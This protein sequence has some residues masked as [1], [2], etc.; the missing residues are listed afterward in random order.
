MQLP[1]ERIEVRPQSRRRDVFRFVIVAGAV[2]VAGAWLLPA[3]YLDVRGRW[4]AITLLAVFLVISLRRS[5]SPG[6]RLLVIPALVFTLGLWSCLFVGMTGWDT[7]LSRAPSNDVIEW[8]R[9]SAHRIKHLDTYDRRDWEFLRDA[10]GD[11]RIVML[12]ES[13]HLVEEYSQAKFNMIRFLHEELGF[14]VLA[15][16]SYMLPAHLANR[17]MA[18]APSGESAIHSIYPI[19]DTATVRRLLN[20]VWS[21]KSRQTSM[22]LAGFDMKMKDERPQE[23]GFI[24]GILE[25]DR[26]LALRYMSSQSRFGPDFNAR[27]GRREVKWNEPLA[28]EFTEFYNE[29]AS[30]LDSLNGRGALPGVSVRTDVS[31]AAQIARNL[32]IQPSY[33]G[34]NT[35]ERVALRDSMMAVNFEYLAEKQYPDQKIIVWAHN[36]HIGRDH[37][38]FALSDVPFIWP[39]WL[40]RL[41]PAKMMGHYVSKRY[42]DNVYVLGL[43]MASG[44][45]RTIHGGERRV[46]P[47]RRDSVE[48]LL[49][50]A[51]VSASFLD[52]TRTTDPVGRE[53]QGSRSKILFEEMWQSIIPA[54]YYDGVLVVSRATAAKTRAMN[55]ADFTSPNPRIR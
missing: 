41:W 27:L 16:E 38:E 19:W 3:P 52:F 31:L 46:R 45:Y 21:T 13:N 6:A 24:Y 39:N 25:G 11:R 18:A 9:S 12:G 32:A 55:T 54:H 49:N 50:D 33:R 10:V 44:H 17:D 1:T 15:F 4:I 5:T 53:W 20:Y 40:A 35:L 34:A 47:S 23:I 8:A 37:L 36:G 51:T 7:W 29:L 42:T 26:A 22:Q 2:V 48:Y 30:E 14:N 28:V 43:Q